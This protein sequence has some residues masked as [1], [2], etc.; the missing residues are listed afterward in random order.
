MI[1]QFTGEPWCHC[2]CL[3]CPGGTVG[4]TLFTLSGIWLKFRNRYGY[5]TFKRWLTAL[6]YSQIENVEIDGI[7]H[8]DAPDFVDAFICS[9]TYKGREMTD[10]ELDRL[11]EDSDYVY[12]AVQDHLY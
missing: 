11:N 1:N 9:A 12:E 2:S 7:N 8:R 10:S 3:G 4:H 5:R 6:D